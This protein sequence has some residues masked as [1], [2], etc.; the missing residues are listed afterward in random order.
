MRRAL[1]LKARGRNAPEKAGLGNRAGLRARHF[2][3]GVL[4]WL[5]SVADTLA[6]IAG[7]GLMR[8]KTG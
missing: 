5:I 7:R 2:H 1:D 4:S 8:I 3:C 6:A